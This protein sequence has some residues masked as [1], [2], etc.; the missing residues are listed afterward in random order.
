MGSY[1]SI[2]SFVT[3]VHLELSRLD[4]VILNAGIQPQS[5]GKSKSTGHEVA[6]QVNYLSTW[7]LAILLLPELKVKPPSGTPGRLTIVG[8]GTSYNA[9]FKN[10]NKKPLLASF[11]E[12]TGI[13][14]NISS[15]GERYSCSKM[16]GHLFLV[17]LVDYVD[18]NDV[19]VNIVDPG[20]TRGS[21]LQRDAG[22]GMRAAG[23]VLNKIMA[24][25][26]AVAS[27]T[28]IDAAVVK[29]QETHGCF[30]MDWDI[31]P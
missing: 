17:K 31:K 1:T 30:V 27:S 6:I 29:G 13:P 23:A 28:Y 19:V 11:D 16:L 21:G 9:K 14:W 5:F 12:D 18:A 8:S 15:V 10:R 24:R 26:L 25:T 20:M 22:A 7:L 4:I 2:Q 3:R